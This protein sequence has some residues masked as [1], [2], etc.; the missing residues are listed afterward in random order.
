MP[1]S[2]VVPLLD[3]LELLLQGFVFS[4]PDFPDLLFLFLLL[5]GLIYGILIRLD[6]LSLQ[7]LLNLRG[8]LPD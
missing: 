8:H 1:E 3:L 7:F 6:Y 2:R 5:Q 4:V